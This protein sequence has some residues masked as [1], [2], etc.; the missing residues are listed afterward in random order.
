MEVGDV[1]SNPK[2]TPPCHS[3][4]TCF[5]S[6]LPQRQSSSCWLG[7]MGTGR[8]GDGAGRLPAAQHQSWPAQCLHGR[9]RLLPSSF[10]GPLL[11]E[12]KGP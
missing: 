10:Q 11:W 9:V 8:D 5:C 12:E 3:G 1:G 2:L 6:V 7:A 4:P